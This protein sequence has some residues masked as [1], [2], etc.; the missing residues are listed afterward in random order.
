MTNLIKSILIV[1]FLIAS[2]LTVYLL[3]IEPFVVT[4]GAT[5]E[6]ASMPMEGDYITPNIT[7]TRAIDIDAPSSDTWNWLMQLGADRAGFF[8]YYFVEKVLGYTSRDPDHVEAS[9]TDFKVGDVIR[10][11]LDEAESIIPYN[12]PVLSVDAED[13][14]VLDKWGTFKVVALS[15]EKS[16]LIVRSHSP[17][18]N[19]LIPRIL[20]R[21]LGTPL[22]FIMERRTLMG[23]KARV[24][25]GPGPRF[26]ATKDM[27]WFAGILLSLI[28][29]FALVF[30]SSNLSSIILPF[31]LSSF[32]LMS[33]FIADPIPIYSIL[34]SAI[35]LLTLAYKY[36]LERKAP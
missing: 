9:Y 11:S 10:G 21:C 6:E 33:V 27:I 7:S 35:I 32:W 17:K 8:S 20:D 15:D 16:R 1:A 4:W 28:A 22:H 3:M 2:Q 25:T 5:N 30:I 19:K 29:L 24:E 13:S 23:I 18:H 31:V 34:I 14:L 36:F 26:S 12:F